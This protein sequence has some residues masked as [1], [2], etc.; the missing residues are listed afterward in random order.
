MQCTNPQIPDYWGTSAAASLRDWSGVLQVEDDSPLDDARAV[1]LHNP[2]PGFELP[3]QSCGTFVPEAQ[4]YTFSVYLRSDVKQFSAALT[5]GWDEK[6]P[7]SVGDRWQ[8]Y[9]VTYLPAGETKLRYA[10]P[11]RIWLQQAGN[12]WIAAPQLESGAQ[13]TPFSL[14]LMDD[15]PLP[16]L[17][18]PKTDEENAPGRVAPL[19]ATVELSY[20]THEE[21]ARVFIESSLSDEA[22]LNISAH[23]L[24]GVMTTLAAGIPFAPTGRQRIVL[25]IKSLPVS[26]YALVA[27]ALSTDGTALARAEDQL[28]KL[29]PSTEQVRMHRA[30]RCLEK[31]G[32]AYVVFGIATSDP[33]DWTLADIAEHGFNTVALFV[34]VLNG[35]AEDEA[36]VIRTRARLDAAH[37]KHLGVIAFLTYDKAKNSDQL[38]QCTARTLRRLKD[39]PA[40]LCW[41]VLD[42]PIGEL[43]QNVEQIYKAAKQ[44][45]PYRPAF[46]NENRWEAG[47]WTNTLLRATDIG[48]FDLY[49]IG[50]HQNSVKLI[51]DKSSAINRDCINARKPSAFW[52]Q[53]YG[54]D[55]AVREPTPDEERAMTYLTF[56]HGTR[57]LL[58]WI[59]KPMNPALWESMKSLREEISR[60]EQIVTRDDAQ[61]V[62]VGTCGLCVLYGLW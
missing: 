1:R 18:W 57:L 27:E 33:T 55:D 10:L 44:A 60:L 26:E 36:S 48:S 23:S 53:L 61:W 17:P 8:R 21:T 30:H 58:Y 45:D 7:I 34:A 50:Q 31:N 38:R 20:Y 41:M 40:I 62:S 37:Q 51:A 43:E 22:R 47:E 56:I 9:D 52:L 4:P 14:A 29:E 2:Q 39:H 46:I 15:H 12:L 42:E 19:Q 5:I 6:R 25:D 59:Y 16:I 3:F 54:Y 13:P 11:V 35:G 49:P 28:V 24:S 32:E